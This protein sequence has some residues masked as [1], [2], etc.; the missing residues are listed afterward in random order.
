MET[1]KEKEQKGLWGNTEKKVL[2][3]K[4]SPTNDGQISKD[5]KRIKFCNWQHA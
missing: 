2:N 1:E 4:R 5:S 3:L